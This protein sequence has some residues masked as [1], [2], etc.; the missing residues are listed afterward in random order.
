M[1]LA[2]GVYAVSLETLLAKVDVLIELS[3]M[4]GLALPT[5]L[6]EEAIERQLKKRLEARRT[7]LIFENRVKML[8]EAVECHPNPIRLAAF[9]KERLPEGT[10]LLFTSRRAFGFGQKEQILESEGLAPEAGGRLF[11]AAVLREWLGLVQSEQARA[12]SVRLAGHPLS[13][14]LVSGQAFSD[15][16][17]DFSSFSKDVL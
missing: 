15:I 14:C 12:L 9:L 11:P 17:L 6:E 8:I 2:G 4:L 3:N 13:L 1:G 5:P 10:G 16:S 7:L